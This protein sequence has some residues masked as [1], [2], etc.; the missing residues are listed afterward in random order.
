MPVIGE[1][2]GIWRYPVKSMAGEKLQSCVLGPSGIPGDRGW[3]TRDETAGEIRGAKKLGALMLCSAHYIS[4]PAAGKI[5]AAEITLPDG[6]KV[7]TGEPEA[8]RRLSELLGRQVTLRP[9]EP[10]SN[11]EHY[12]RGMP[13]NPDMTA[14]LREMFGRLEN[15]PLPDFASW[16]TE[17]QELFQF[18]SPLGTYF[19]AYPVHAVTTSTLKTLESKT[20]GS[21]FDVRRFRPNFVIESDSDGLV[22]QKWVGK[23]VKI[24][25]TLIEVR[26]PCV[27]CVITTLQ[28]K[29]LPKDPQ[30]LR[31]IVRDA[32]QNVGIYARVTTPG[33]IKLGDTVEVGD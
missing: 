3:A 6:S 13:D 2:A 28:Q 17:M 22:E 23:R 16:P 29:D 26:V 32:A 10:A 20:P 33:T 19:D 27:R 8:D 4:Q 30:V 14:E 21:R 7:R 12:K 25:E 24:G 31:T 9:L 11:K 5:P 15:E 18:T 1:I